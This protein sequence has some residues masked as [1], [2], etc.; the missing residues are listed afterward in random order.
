MNEELTKNLETSETNKTEIDFKKVRTYMIKDAILVLIT[1]TAIYSSIILGFS[2]ILI[3]VTNYIG[4]LLVI[5]IFQLLI[6]Y[7]AKETLKEEN[8]SKEDGSYYKKELIIMIIKIDCFCILLFTGPL[9]MRLLFAWILANAETLLKIGK[10]LLNGVLYIIAGAVIFLTL[11]IVAYFQ[12]RI[13]ENK[14]ERK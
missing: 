2:E 4:I 6:C 9:L 7:G 5:I 8:I 3:K 10:C 11:F 13:N 1:V 12:A 14:E